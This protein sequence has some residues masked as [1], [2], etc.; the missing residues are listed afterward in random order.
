MLAPK[1]TDKTII[2]NKVAAATSFTTAL[3][4][5]AEIVGYAQASSATLPK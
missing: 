3:D 2:D 1:G 5:T 4:T